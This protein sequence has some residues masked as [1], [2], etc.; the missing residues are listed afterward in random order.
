MR[1]TQPASLGTPLCPR[2]N[3]VPVS[4]WVRTRDSPVP[5]QTGTG[6]GRRRRTSSPARSPQ[7]QGGTPSRR[8]KGQYTS[9]EGLSPGVARPAGPV[10]S[11]SAVPQGRGYEGRTGPRR[12]TLVVLLSLVTLTAG[13]WERAR[14]DGVERGGRGGTPEGGVGRGR[15]PWTDVTCSDSDGSR[16]RRGH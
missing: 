13:T 12:G 3:L 8:G 9:T 5:S 16:I 7:D 6:S 14:V 1:C 4:R 2:G 10:R 11:L 15:T